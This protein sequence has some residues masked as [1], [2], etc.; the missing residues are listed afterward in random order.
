MLRH[1]G[2]VMVKSL[3]RRGLAA[4][5]FASV[6][7]IQGVAV[8]SAMA[9][10]LPSKTATP[11][12]AAPP[13]I[14]VF[15]WTGFYAGVQ[16]GYQFG[17]DRAS[18]ASPFLGS[19]SL[20]FN[21]NGVAGGG[22]AG[23]NYALQPV[24]GGSPL[25]VGIEGDIEG[26]DD[27]K[28]AGAFGGLAATST[29]SD[30]KGSVRGRL[31]IAVDRVLFYATGGAAFADFATRYDAAPLAGGTNTFDRSRA[32]Y[33]VGGGIEYAFMNDFSVRAEYRYSDYGTFTDTLTPAAPGLATVTH[34][35]T[36]NR[37][38]AGVSYKFNSILPA[39]VVA[40]Y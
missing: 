25:V 33:T 36:D 15:S 13:S 17:R 38:E 5:A 2:D 7:L 28:A 23:Y 11:V 16:A 22:H 9:A 4:I 26:A 39:P 19:A 12:F 1:D 32:G 29:R 30:I 34:R 18:L 21:P 14:P 10:D 20:G 8:Q 37:V 27:R 3:P 24:F 6:A 35:E 31:G 40:K